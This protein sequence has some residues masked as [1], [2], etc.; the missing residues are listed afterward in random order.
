[1]KKE[2]KLKKAKQL[3]FEVKQQE[4]AELRKENDTKHSHYCICGHV[5]RQHGASHSINF[6]DGPCMECD[7]MGFQYSLS[8]NEPKQ[9][10]TD[11]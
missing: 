6:T 3:L 7:C 1:M 2:D 5:R 9:R 8:K 10:I 11:K 4:L